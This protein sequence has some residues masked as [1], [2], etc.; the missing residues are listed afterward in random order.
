MAYQNF[1]CRFFK[2][3]ASIQK[4]TVNVERVIDLPFVPFN[5][6][7]LNFETDGSYAEQVVSV[8]WVEK[9]QEFHIRCENNHE[10]KP[11]ENDLDGYID[12]LLSTGWARF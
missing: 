12:K 3:L 9:A 7:W 6:I 10:R 2:N 4:G 1:K 11:G 5:G 8:A